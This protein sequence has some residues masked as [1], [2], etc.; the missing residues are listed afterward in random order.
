MNR[1]RMQD[2]LRK[3]A[4]LA[5]NGS[6][7]EKQ[8]ARAMLAALAEEYGISPDRLFDEEKSLCDFDYKNDAESDVVA[9]VV[10]VVLALDTCCVYPIRKCVR[11]ECTAAQAAE[12][13]TLLSV[14][15]PDFR[16]QRKEMLARLDA[17]PRAF[18]AVNRIFNS[19]CNNA[20]TPLSPKQRQAIREASLFVERS[21]V[22]PQLAQ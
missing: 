16:K 2:R 10:M 13:R 9:Q 14:Y 21:E 4:A 22:H 19:K 5:E 7:G 3:I 20:P 1:E 12:I 18:I 11:A 6:E 17:L 15:L 8:N